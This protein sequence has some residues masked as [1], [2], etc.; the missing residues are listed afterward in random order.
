MTENEFVS[1]IERLKQSDWFND[2]KTIDYSKTVTV[3]DIDHIRYLARKEAVETVCD[4]FKDDMTK[5]GQWIEELGNVLSCRCSVCERTYK[6]YED[7]I[8]GYPYCA[9][10]GAKMDE[11]E[12]ENEQ[13]YR[14]R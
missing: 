11:S 5:H 2:G 8:N 3:V 1:E 4:L 7:D 13:I 6:I 14:C 10:C 12:D 9:W